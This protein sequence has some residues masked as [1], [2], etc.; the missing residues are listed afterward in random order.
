[1]LGPLLTILKPLWVGMTKK[2]SA[3]TVPLIFLLHT[4]HA[5]EILKYLSAAHVS[6]F[7]KNSMPDLSDVICEKLFSHNK[8]RKGGKG[9]GLFRSHLLLYLNRLL[10][11]WR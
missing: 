8:K 11:L 10:K 6:G 1:M 3:A 7:G 9:F 2:P 4:Y 5:E